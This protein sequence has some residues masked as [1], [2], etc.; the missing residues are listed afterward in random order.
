VALTGFRCFDLSRNRNRN[1][2]ST[3]AV[4]LAFISSFARDARIRSQRGLRAHRDLHP[5]K[6]RVE[7]SRGTNN[8][9][10]AIAR[11]SASRRQKSSRNTVRLECRLRPARHSFAS[12]ARIAAETP[13]DDRGGSMIRVFM[14]N[15][16]KT[17]RRVIKIRPALK[18]RGKE[19]ERKEENRT[20]PSRQ[21]VCD[22]LS[23]AESFLARERKDRG[24]GWPCPPL[25]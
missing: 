19:K 23:R 13:R 9:V 7:N 18:G 11:D 16:V 4:P 12:K 5:R 25:G 20:R 24:R 21:Q 15:R 8:R 2:T 1:A 3:P 6:I 17:R 22:E 14:R 10:S